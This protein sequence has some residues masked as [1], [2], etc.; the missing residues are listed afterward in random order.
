M[1]KDIIETLITSLSSIPPELA[2]ALLAALPI[3]ELR[4]ALPLAITVFELDPIVAYT[5]TVLGNVIPLVL[6]FLFLPPFVRFAEARSPMLHQVLDKYFRYLLHKHKD[7][8]HGYGSFAL[9]LF[10]AI[11]LPVS[12]VWTGSVLAILFDIR[13][14]SAIV[15]ILGGLLT[16]GLI[17]LLIT[18]GTLGA[19][20]FLV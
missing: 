17:V 7:R 12:G 3:T 2:S 13:R 10:V 18:R 8:F 9:F 14:E 15:A 4:G 1:G 20:S 6:I 16:A 5:A 19:L 11:P